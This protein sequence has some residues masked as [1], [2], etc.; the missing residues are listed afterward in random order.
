MRRLRPPSRLNQDHGRLQQDH[1]AHRVGRMAA[2]HSLVVGHGG[3]AAGALRTAGSDHGSLAAG[4]PEV[5]REMCCG[6]GRS[7]AGI[8]PAAGHHSRAGEVAHMDRAMA[9]GRG[10]TGMLAV[11]PY[12]LN[13]PM[14]HM[15]AD[16]ALRV[17]TVMSL[18]ILIVRLLSICLA[19]RRVALV[20]LSIAM[21]LLLLVCAVVAVAVALTMALALTVVIL[22]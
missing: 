22:A 6:S 5:G 4:V 21:L 17:R 20:L 14:L 15:S 16:L 19:L 3:P 1:R 18:S 8:G 13:A 12:R 9:E 7:F 11:E 10:S 2:H